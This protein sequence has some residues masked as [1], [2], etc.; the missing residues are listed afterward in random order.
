M[1]EDVGDARRLGGRC[2]AGRRR[3]RHKA[4]GKLRVEQA[5]SVVESGAEDL[6]AGNV[7]EG[8]GDA[9][10]DLHVAGIDRLGG[11]EA[12]QRGAEGANQEDRLDQVA[13]RLL[14]RERGELAIIERAFRHHAIDTERKLFGDLRQRK[15]RHLPVAAPFMREQAMGVLDGAFAALDRNVH[16]Q[17]FP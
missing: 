2:F 9:A 4:L 6:A 17:S 13:A 7:L 5:V 12:R 1:S 3:L 15:L 14:D 11:A 16:R 8:R 10:A